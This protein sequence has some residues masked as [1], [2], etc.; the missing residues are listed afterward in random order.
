MGKTVYVVIAYR[1]D[2]NDRHSY[3]VGVFDKK[4]DAIIC[5]YNHN[6]YRG[7]KYGCAVEKFKLNGDYENIKAKEVYRA[8]SCQDLRTCVGYRL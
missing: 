2:C 4:K 3:T 5:A 1:W 7:G 6:I 8:I